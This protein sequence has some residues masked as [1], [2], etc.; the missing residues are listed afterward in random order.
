MNPE[1]YTNMAKKTK[2]HVAIDLE[3][4]LLE[5]LRKI[6]DSRHVTL[7]KLI[8]ALIQAQLINMNLLDGLLNGMDNGIEDF[9]A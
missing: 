1:V 2:R 7:S 4:S 6:A 3:K 5:D 9:D 8:S